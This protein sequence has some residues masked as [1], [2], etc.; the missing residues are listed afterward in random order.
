MQKDFLDP[1]LSLPSLLYLVVAGFL[2]W[3]GNRAY[4]WVQLWLNRKKPAAEIDE[5]QARTVKTFAE[6]R[7][8]NAEADTEL[9]AIIQRL[10]LRIDQM[11]AGI[12]AIRDE[13]D[14]AN[15]ERDNA[16]FELRQEKRLTAQLEDQLKV[17]QHYI[18]RLTLANELKITLK[19]LDA[20]KPPD[21]EVDVGSKQDGLND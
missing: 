8:I 14:T 9:N 2:G 16:Q 20:I 13:R 17:D 4:K 7:R 1:S 19:E 18:N 21:K 6:A 12:D 11:Q 3:I 5:T 15:A 10:H